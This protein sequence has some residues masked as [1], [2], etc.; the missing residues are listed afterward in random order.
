MLETQEPVSRAEDGT[1]QYRLT[2]YAYDA[3]GNRARKQALDGTTRYQ[4]DAQGRVFTVLSPEGQ[5]HTAKR[6]SF[7]EVFPI[8][9]TSFLPS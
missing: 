4:Y 3:N 7:E 9:D 6:C 2:Q 1:D 8:G 5:V